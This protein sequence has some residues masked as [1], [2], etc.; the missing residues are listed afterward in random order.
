MTYS[1]PPEDLPPTHATDLDSALQRQ[2]VAA[3][4]QHFFESCKGSLQA[5]IMQCEW[6]ICMAEVPTLVLRCS[7]MRRNR[8]VLNHI[9]SITERLAQ[10][11]TQAKVKVYSPS[12]TEPPLEVRVDE[13]SV[14]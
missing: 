8:Q 14:Y 10:F 7:D 5:I 2:L 13:R 6:K 9:P 12:K 11:S 4:N 3:V 1:L